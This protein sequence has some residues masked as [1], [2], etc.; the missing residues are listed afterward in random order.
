MKN[1]E[2]KE[3]SGL[4]NKFN[5]EIAKFCA[6]QESRYT[7]NA[8]LIEPGATIVTDGFLLIKVTTPNHEIKFEDFPQIPGQ[9]VVR[10]SGNELFPRQA[11]LDLASSIP[12]KKKIPVLNNAAMLKTGKEQVGFISTDLKLTKPTIVSKLRVNFP[13]YEGLFPSEEAVARVAFNSKHMAELCGF[14]SKFAGSHTHTVIMTVYS[15]GKAIKLE[16]Q[17]SYTGQDAT[18]LL[19]PVDLSPSA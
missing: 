9:E 18:A 11:A 3:P 15:R 1:K 7:I 2:V 14:L 13:P 6:K 10:P 19:M 12:S 5:F 16:S 17:N 8:V 4:Y